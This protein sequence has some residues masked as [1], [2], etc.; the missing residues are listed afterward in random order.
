MKLYNEVIVCYDV[1]DNRT[2]GRIFERLKDI[3]LRPIQKSV[4]WGHVNS[5][6][7]RAILRLFREELNRDTDMAFLVRADLGATV[8]RN[9]FGYA[10]E[11]FALASHA[12]L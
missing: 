1:E 9:G 2:R 8:E 11:T 5:A 3:G 6:E 10:S 12:T 4:F 7:E